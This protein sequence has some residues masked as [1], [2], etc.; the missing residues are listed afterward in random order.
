MGWSRQRRVVMLRRRIARSLALTERDTSGQ[1]RLGFA[2]IDGGR[3]VWEY[4]VLV[5][6]LDAEVLTIGQLYRD[7]ADCENGFD[8]LRRL[9]HA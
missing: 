1:L 4:A 7:R 3:E 2:E 8:E 6:S 9:H 5:T